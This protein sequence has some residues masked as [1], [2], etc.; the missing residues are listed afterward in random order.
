MMN[1][2][3]QFS[4]HSNNK[5]ATQCLRWCGGVSGCSWW[6]LVCIIWCLQTVNAA[7]IT[8]ELCEN[9]NYQI[10]ID[11]CYVT[12]PITLVKDEPLIFTV[13]ST[14]ASNITSVLFTPKNGQ[15]QSNITEVPREI[16]RIFPQ[17]RKL[18]IRGNVQSI[19]SDDFTDAK[20]L[21]HLTLNNQLECLSSH[22]FTY[23][24]NLSSITL[25]RNRIS[26]IEDNAFDGLFVLEQL[27]LSKNELKSL[28]R[29]M[30]AGLTKLN[31]LNLRDN[32]IDTIEDGTFDLPELS[33]LI[34]SKNH[35]KTL[36]D[37][38]FQ[39]APLLQ[40]LTIDNNNLET[41]GR[42]MY[43][44]KHANR[45]IMYQNKIRDIDIIEFAKLPELCALWLRDSGF[46]FRNR[47][48][49]QY[50]PSNSKVNYLDISYN[51]LS[52]PND[53]QRLQIFKELKTITLDD[54]E[55]VHIE[56]GNQTI[57]EIFPVLETFHMSRNKWNCTWLKPVV[58]QATKDRIRT[59][60]NT[61]ECE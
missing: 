11:A 8:C 52:D 41:I 6:W 19:S 10:E 43:N 1:S 22:V 26:R 9:E 38:I 18:E 61:A 30:F 32:D 36:S 20:N 5:S 13:T 39:G 33:E 25:S 28:S 55:Y 46:T 17:L 57:H 27:T 15:L 23:A 21:R 12:K 44:L 48:I 58:E 16:F 56:L 31:Y 59:V 47:T 3:K 53:L 34:L 7:N 4:S 37:H 49:D 54:N 35:L 50:Q 60:L 42:S 14:S 40:R 29:L 45:I 51:H 24:S 2:I